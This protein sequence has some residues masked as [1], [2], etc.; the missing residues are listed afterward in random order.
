M[1]LQDLKIF[2]FWIHFWYLIENMIHNIKIRR[3]R[4]FFQKFFIANK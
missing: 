4:F 2:R 3:T 1:L